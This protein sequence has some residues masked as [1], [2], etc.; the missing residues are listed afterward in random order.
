MMRWFHIS[1][2][3]ALGL[4]VV[5]R[6][7]G[8]RPNVLFVAVDDLNDWTTVYDPDNPIRTP[9]LERLADR[10]M[11]FS[12]AYCVSP[13]CNPSRVATMTGLR[14]TTTGVYGNKSEWRKALPGVVTIPRY[15][16][17]HGYHVTGAG[18]IFHHHFESAF[19]DEGSFHYFQKLSPHPMPPRR[20]NGITNWVG[21]RDGA[22]TLPIFDWGPWPPDEKDTPDYKSVEYARGYLAREQRKPFFLAVGIFRPHSPFFAPG[23]YFASYPLGE[24]EVP[25]VRDDDRDDLPSG[26]LRMLA[27]G[28][29]F[30]YRTMVSHGQLPRAIQAY[31][32]CA[33]FADAQVGRL[34]DALDRSPHAGNTIIVLWSD[35]GFHLGEKQHWEKFA[36]WEKTTRVPLLVV[37]PGVVK[38]GGRCE[39][40]VSLLDLYPTLVDLCRLKPRR[41]LEGFN[42]APF[43]RGEKFRRGRPVLTTW[44]RGNHAVRSSRW[45]YISYGDGTGELYDHSV[46]PSEWHNLAVAPGAEHE[47]VMRDLRKWIPTREA[48]QV[49]DMVSD[50]KQE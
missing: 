10:G 24:F 47:R 36:L 37:A 41:E 23:R 25:P 14:P 48:P 9:N 19:H 17:S 30:L 32:A 35:H 2:L 49:A 39:E 38:K 20:L 1:L 4:P 3:V 28:K 22:A 26:G 44:G 29:P 18:K 31:A 43:L 46:D 12:R 5:A 33:T 21:G 6:E 50:R 34:L 42:L 13:A 8:P 11:F 15:F 16:M 45:R 7:E 27:E 40:P